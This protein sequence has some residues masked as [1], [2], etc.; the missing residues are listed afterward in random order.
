[1]L[2]Q[3]LLSQR[4]RLFDDAPGLRVNESRRLLAD[5]LDASWSR[6]PDSPC[7]SGVKAFPVRVKCATLAWHTLQAALEN[8][9]EDVSTEK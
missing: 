1:M 2:T 6:T 3:H 4:F 9:S 5:V 8:K 7:L